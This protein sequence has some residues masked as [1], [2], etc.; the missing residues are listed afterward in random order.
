M[1]SNSLSSF[2]NLPQ[3]IEFLS[4]KR[5]HFTELPADLVEKQR[6]LFLDLSFNRLSDV[7]VLGQLNCLKVLML[8]GNQITRLAALGSIRSL[9]ELD[10]DSNLVERI[11]E[12][13]CFEHHQSIAVL[14]LQHNP[15]V[16]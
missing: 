1:N 16:E 2:D 14:N 5:N 6:L 11:E 4:L 12:A 9:V 10:L 13:A 8:K 7:D 3:H 15:V